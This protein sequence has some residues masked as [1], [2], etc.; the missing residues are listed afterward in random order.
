MKILKTFFQIFASFCA[1]KLHVGIF[2]LLLFN[3]VTETFFEKYLEAFFYV[4]IYYM[5]KTQK[6]AKKR[7]TGEKKVKYC[8]K[9]CDYSTSNKTDYHR[10]LKTQKHKN[11]IFT[12]N[13]ILEK[14]LFSKKTQKVEYFSCECGK[15]FKSKSGL[16]KHNKKC[17]KT[18]QSGVFSVSKVSKKSFQNFQKF[19]DDNEE[20][21]DKKLKQIQLENELL[22]QQKLKMDIERMNKNVQN[23]K[24]GPQGCANYVQFGDGGN[25]TYNNNNISINMYL[26]ENC[27]N[28]MSL[29]DFMQN[30]KISLQ[31]LDYTTKNGYMAGISNILMSQLG[32]IAPNER[33]IHCSDQKRLQFYVKEDDTWK[34][35]QNNQKINSS[36]NKIK[37]KQYDKIDKWMEENPNWQSDP[38]L[39]DEYQHMVDKIAGPSEQKEKMKL[40]KKIQKELAKATNIKDE[41]QKMKNK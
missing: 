33:P 2:A 4:S 32:D 6:N 23:P 20:D 40:S 24:N 26:N 36:I 8:C 5:K 19:P 10:H 37:I 7:L 34:K 30:I 11:K 28:A 22:K 12:G 17:K 39:V 35:D 1:S 3:F 38:A 16:W 15:K 29:E 13:P 21:I 31:D 9:I 27:K 14:T 25:Q 18:S 41:I